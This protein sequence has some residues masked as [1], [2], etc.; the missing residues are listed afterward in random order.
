MKN[1]NSKACYVI[2]DSGVNG[3]QVVKLPFNGTETILDAIAAVPGL[4]ADAGKRTIYLL[5]KGPAG[6]VDQALPVDW[7]AIVQRGDTKTNYALQSGDRV[8]VAGAR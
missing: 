6:A 4:A 8:Y 5:R 7:A 2:L 3:E 1:N